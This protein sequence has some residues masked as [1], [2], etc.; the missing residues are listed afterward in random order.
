[1]TYERLGRERNE[2]LRLLCSEC[3]LKAHLL[4][5][6]F[7]HFP[8]GAASLIQESQAAVVERLCPEQSLV[9]SEDD[10]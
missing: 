1:L 6:P 10:D 4:P 7:S 5:I 2:D 8:E 3:H 9:E